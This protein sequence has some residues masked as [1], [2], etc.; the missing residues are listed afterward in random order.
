M[1]SVLLQVKGLSVLL[2]FV[3]ADTSVKRVAAGT[4]V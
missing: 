4:S 2:L 1:H 3:A